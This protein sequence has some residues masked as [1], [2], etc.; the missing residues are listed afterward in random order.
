MAPLHV[1]PSGRTA[2]VGFA[3]GV[4]RVVLRCADA[5][6]LVD[7]I[8]PH[9]R[10]V[11]AAAYSPSGA[12]LATASIDGTVFF[13]SVGE[14]GVN[15]EPVGFASVPGPVTA[16]SWS[17]DGTTLLVGCE[18]LNPQPSTLNPLTPN[19]KPQAPNPEPQT[20]NPLS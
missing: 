18:T 5:W 3:D 19:P 11:T 2:L 16:I 20:P 13:L 4:V 7:C 12:A 8:K 10:A 15:L 14:H 1:D 6:K 17:E 9:R